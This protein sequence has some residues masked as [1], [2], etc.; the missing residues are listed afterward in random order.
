M[1]TSMDGW[2]EIKGTGRDS[3]EKRQKQELEV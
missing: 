2:T 3:K 1:E